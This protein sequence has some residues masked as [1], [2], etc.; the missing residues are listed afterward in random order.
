[1]DNSFIGKVSWYNIRNEYGFIKVD[2]LYDNYG[3]KEVYYHKKDMFKPEDLCEGDTVSFVLRKERSKMSA[4]KIS[5]ILS[6]DA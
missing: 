6:Y 4:V 2:E 3:G 5:K 1:M